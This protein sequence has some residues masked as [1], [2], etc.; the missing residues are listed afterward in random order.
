MYAPIIIPLIGLVILFAGLYVREWAL[1]IKTIRTYND[2]L[3]KVNKNFEDLKKQIETLNTT[4][5]QLK[6]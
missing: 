3:E 2:I 5:K 1:R 4:I 6:E